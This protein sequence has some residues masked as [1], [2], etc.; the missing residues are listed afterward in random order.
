MYGVSCHLI[1]LI[2]FL[3]IIYNSPFST[4]TAFII[5]SLLKQS[6]AMKHNHALLKQHLELVLLLLI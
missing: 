3:Y 2:A 1:A 6:N 4:I 5:I